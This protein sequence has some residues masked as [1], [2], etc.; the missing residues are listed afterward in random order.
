MDIKTDKG[1]AE[2]KE[3]NEETGT[4]S[5]ARDDGGWDHESSHGRYEK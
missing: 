3:S 4:G 1:K 5:Q 2:K